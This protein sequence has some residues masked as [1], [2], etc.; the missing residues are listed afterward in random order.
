MGD[1]GRRD[2]PLANVGRINRI[3]LELVSENPSR[4]PIEYVI[5]PGLA[6]VFLEGGA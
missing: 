6:G 2:A 4:P 5:R 3:G 1:R